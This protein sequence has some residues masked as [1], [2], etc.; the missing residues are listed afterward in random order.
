MRPNSKVHEYVA[1]YVDDLCLVMKEPQGFIS[2]L[3]QVCKFKFKATGP[4]KCHVGID[5][6]RDPDGTLKHI[7][8]KCIQ[9]MVD[10]YECMFG[11]KHGQTYHSPLEPSNHPKLATSEFLDQEGI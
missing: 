5:F 3:D 1:V 4:I 8:T 2:L 11:E 7:P 9:K 6:E 10:N